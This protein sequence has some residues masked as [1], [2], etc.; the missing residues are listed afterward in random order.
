MIKKVMS[1]KLWV[2]GLVVFSLFVT[3]RYCYAQS[4]SSTELIENGGQYDGR[5]ALYQ[6]EV[7]GEIMQRKDGAWVNINDG[8]NSIG[9]W[10]PSELA[11]TIKYKGSYKTQGDIIQIEG[12]FNRVCTQHGGDLDIH[13][14]SLRKI[15][16]GWIKQERIIPAKCNFLIILMVLACLILILRISVIR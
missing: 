2:M 13:A 14:I 16:S 5:E 4:V 8:E 15:K 1:Y 3:H 6:G 11:T 10:M 9:V 7:I 12:I